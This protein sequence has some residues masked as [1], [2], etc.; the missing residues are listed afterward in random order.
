ML[1]K[2]PALVRGGRC[3]NLSKRLKWNHAEFCVGT[4]LGMLFGAHTQG[5]GGVG[6]VG[7]HVPD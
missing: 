3:G 1:I 7:R 2:V 6:G 4:E 5:R